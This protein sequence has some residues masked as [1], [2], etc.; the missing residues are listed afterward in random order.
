MTKKISIFVDLDESI[1]TQVMLGNK[2]IVQAQGK[3]IT[4]V[5]TKTGTK[6]IQN[7]LFVLDLD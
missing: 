4:S 6:L 5:R 7:L 1:K 2:D 3:G